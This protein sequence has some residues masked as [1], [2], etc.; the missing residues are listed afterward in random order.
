MNIAY[1]FFYSF[2]LIFNEY[3]IV[4][5][6]NKNTKILLPILL[7]VSVV[8]GVLLGINLTPSA[9]Q[10]SQSVSSYFQPDK[11]SLLLKLIEREYV[12][13]V[14]TQDIIEEV[15][16]DLLK[17][18]DPHTTYIPAS[19]MKAVT[20]DM[21]GNFSGIGVQFV[22]QNDTVMIVDVISGGPSKE[23]G[24]LAGDRIVEVNGNVIAGKEVQTDSVVS[25]LRGKE[26]T[27]VDVGIYRPGFPDLLEFTIV[28]GQIPLYSI[29]ISYMIS[30]DIGF[31]KINRFA[32]TT[33]GEF[34]QA[35]QTLIEANAQK[36]IIDLRGN[37]GGSL[38]AV[39]QMVDEFLPEKKLIVYTEGKSQAR[40]NY[41]STDR[42]RWK[43]NEVA[44]LID[45]FSASASEI[46][47]GAIQDNDR[48]FII[49]RRSFG[50]GL[51]Q[52][53]IPFFDGSA[54]RLTVARFYTPSGRSIQK[55]YDN[56]VDDYMND[57]YNRVMHNELSQKDSIEFDESLEYSTVNGRKVYGGGG[58]MPD[59]F[60]PVDTTS[61]TPFLSA[62]AS[63]NL[64]YY[65]AFD[66][67]DKHRAELNQISNY[68]EM[69]KYLDSIDIMQ[70]F[71]NHTK[72]RGIA[73]NQKEY[74]QSK[75]LISTQLYAY[76]SRN[77][78]GDS[79]F[80]PIIFETDNTVKKAVE[81]LNSQVD[82]LSIS[83]LF[84]E[85]N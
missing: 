16:P 50:K 47:A 73:F 76:I 69:K 49:G 80:Y 17:E 55:P 79:G 27:P 12:D 11:L 61:I 52:E 15:I 74:Q 39:I 63:K 25:I 9:P 77:I 30:P 58:I 59:V 44:V 38:Q 8:A 13:S 36:L 26:G 67:A 23:L 4:S 56:G 5:K 35:M 82:A 83:A 2:G 32:E 51:V 60:V 22:M 1:N 85:T 14:N 10:T 21:Q 3:N 46:F 31:I 65:F 62:V 64:I 24:I 81:V 42:G 20:E 6:M 40:Y 37:S 54:L 29:D 19:Q 18:L 43:Q 45:E 48:G 68:I 66:Y 41:Y 78:L 70:K 75:E 57:Y 7:S 71:I 34:V 72:Q 53:Q 84:E 28:R 33:Y